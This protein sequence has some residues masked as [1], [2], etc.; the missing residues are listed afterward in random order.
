MSPVDNFDSGVISSSLW[1]V[2]SAGFSTDNETNGPHDPPSAP[3][4]VEL[5]GVGDM[6]TSKTSDFSDYVSATLS[7]QIQ[8]GG[9]ENAPEPEDTLLVEYLNCSGKRKEALT[10]ATKML[11]T[12]LCLCLFGCG[13]R[14]YLNGQASEDA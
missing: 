10:V 1:S 8:A 14:N 6:L 11:P 9:H 2:C 12:L 4:A 7:Y 3:Y 13:D 5:D